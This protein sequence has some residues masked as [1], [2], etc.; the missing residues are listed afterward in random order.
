MRGAMIWALAGCAAT[1]ALSA[2]TAAQAESFVGYTLTGDSGYNLIGIDSQ[3]NV[4]IQSSTGYDIYTA[5]QLVSQPVSLTGFT[6]DDGMVCAFAS[7]A[8]AIQTGE[9]VCNGGNHVVGVEMNGTSEIVYLSYTG[10]DIVTVGT[11]DL[12]FVN[13]SGDFVVR[14]GLD[15]EIRE[16][17]PAPEP[18]TLALLATAVAVGAVV[19]SL[20]REAQ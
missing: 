19:S 18:G 9:S 14:D 1:A 10:M 2:A 13:T 3:G 8:T 6:A 12:L 11:A 5:G 17:S 20:R 4:A 16:F 7:T 15:E